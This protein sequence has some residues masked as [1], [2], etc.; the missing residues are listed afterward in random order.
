MEAFSRDRARLTDGDNSELDPLDAEITNEAEVERKRRSFQELISELRP[1]QQTFVLEYLKGRDAG[2][3][4]LSYMRVYGTDNE[5]SAS[6][7]ASYL[8]S[9]PRVRAV[10]EAFQADARA[11]LED[12][13]IP[14]VEL[15]PEAQKIILEIAQGKVTKGATTRLGAARELLD[16]ALGKPTEKR[17]VVNRGEVAKVAEVY[18]VRLSE[19]RMMRH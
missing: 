4:T 18:A 13:L 8:L 11:E 7:S 14:W 15:V 2:N 5:N 6:A 19:E 1:L 10:I 12:R 17:E 16:R 9:T 3:A